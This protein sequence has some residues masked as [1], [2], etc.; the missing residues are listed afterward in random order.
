MPVRSILTVIIM[1]VM[2]MILLVSPV[3]AEDHPSPVSPEPK[4]TIKHVVIISIDGLNYEGFISA[5]TPNMDYLAKEGVIDEK[6]LT[7]KVNSVE[8]SEAGL[9][10]GTF[11]EDHKFI[12]A[13]DK[14]E[15]ESLVDQIR[16]TGS[17]VSLIDG[18]GGKL[19]NI[20]A[21]SYSKIDARTSDSQVFLTAIQQFIKDRPFFT[22]IYANDCLDGLLSLNE[23]TYFRSITRVDQYVGEMINCLRKEGIYKQ[24]LIIVTSPRS[25]SSSNL[26]PFIIYGPGCKAGVRVENTML[27]D[28]A[29]T[30]SHMLGLKPLFNARGIPLYDV[31]KVEPRDQLFIL[32]KWIKELKTERMA[33]WNR[34]DDSQEDLYRT[35][36][37]LMAVKEERQ[38]IFHFAGQREEAI[39]NL[40]DR[41]AKERKIAM[42][43]LLLMAMGYVVEYRWLKKKFLL[44]R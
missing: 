4:Q 15:V 34:Y 24:T 43:C 31:M 10:T 23:K 20:G 27:V 22:Y 38:N 28:V 13:G 42:A 40:Q 41:I 35:I 3:A 17:K 29:P 19:Q 25:S 37:Q 7:F 36:K 11:P 14:V 1:S 39:I 6:A 33:T 32:N 44:F 9:L 12:T 21:G 30:I 5:Y 26:A 8:A 16:K 2:V 18:S